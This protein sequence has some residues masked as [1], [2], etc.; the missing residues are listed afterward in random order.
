VSPDEK[1]LF[2]AMQSPLANPNNAAY[3]GSDLV[4]IFKMELHDQEL[5]GEYVYKME[6]PEV[7]LKDNENKSRKQSDVKVSEMVGL[8][9]DEV[10]ILERISKSTRLY[11]VEMED[12]DNS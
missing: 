7:Y 8:G 5:V 3:K 6:K 4:R 9:S 2:F 1:Y 11:K 10:I 12:A